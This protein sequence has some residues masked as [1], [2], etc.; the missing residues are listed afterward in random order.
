MTVNVYEEIENYKDICTFNVDNR[1]EF[2]KF[3]KFVNK[4]IKNGEMLNYDINIIVEPSPVK[5]WLM[6]NA[7]DTN[8]YIHNQE[9]V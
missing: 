7:S 1:K 4:K 8:V 6:I 9:D 3:I 5:E 2:E